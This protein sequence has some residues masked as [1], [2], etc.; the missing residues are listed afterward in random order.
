M[1]GTGN[2]QKSQ[3]KPKRHC[4]GQ[5]PQMKNTIK[6]YVNLTAFPKRCSWD[7]PLIYVIPYH[8]RRGLGGQFKTLSGHLSA[9]NAKIRFLEKM[10]V[11]DSKM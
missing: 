4:F 8:H 3:F 11:S 7:N 1:S 6:H 9:N 2:N 10:A 5:Q